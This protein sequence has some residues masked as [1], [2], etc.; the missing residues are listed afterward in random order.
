MRAHAAYV[1]PS[2][3]A[4]TLAGLLVLL[5]LAAALGIGFGTVNVLALGDRERSASIIGELRLPRV[6]LAGLVGGA[7][8]TSGA[9]LQALVRNPLASPYVLGISS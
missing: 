2:R 7:L 6:L 3:Q 4:A 8:A 1:T 9:V 5:V